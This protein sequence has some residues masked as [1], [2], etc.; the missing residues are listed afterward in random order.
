MLANKVTTAAI[1]T[2]V[3][4]TAISISTSV[5]PTWSLP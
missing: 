4:A 5:K 1:I 3:M 2:K